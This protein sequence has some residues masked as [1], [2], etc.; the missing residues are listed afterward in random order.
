MSGV[1]GRSGGARRGTG[2]TQRR[3]RLNIDAAEKLAVIVG[4]RRALQPATTP[5]SVV[6]QWIN[7]EW[8]EL[9]AYF[10]QCTQQQ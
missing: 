3:L 10:Q 7:D 5:E 1:K 2:P 4:H 9:D 8:I 6:E